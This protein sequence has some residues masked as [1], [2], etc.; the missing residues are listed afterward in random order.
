[1]AA[2]FSLLFAASFWG[3]VWYPLRLLEQGGLSGS[4]QMLLSYGAA[5]IALMLFMRPRLTRMAGRWWQM[6]LMSLA[7]G[8]A[9]VGFVVAM[10]DGTVARSLLLFHLSPVWATLLARIFLGEHV[11]RVMRLALPLGLAG[12]VLMVWRP[13]LGIPWPLRWADGLALSAG[14]AFAVANV[15]TRGMSGLDTGQKTAL[16]WIGVIVTALAAIWVWH[17]PLPQAPLYIWGGSAVLGIGGFFFVTMAAVYG[18]S[19][20]PVQRSSVILLIE[21]LIGALTAWWLVGEALTPQEWIGGGLI[22]AAGI[23]AAHG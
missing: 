22:L 4:W 20:L 9:N 14:F 12:A 13:E 1:M 23:L 5:L 17:E 15:L 10:L 7:A 16:T 18:V 21:I 8:W 2:V 3:L 19:R 6:G 11:S